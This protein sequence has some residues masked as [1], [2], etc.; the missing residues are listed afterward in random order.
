MNGDVYEIKSL[1]AKL[2]GNDLA[3]IQKAI[4]D[5]KETY[6]KNQQET[7]QILTRIDTRIEDLTN[8]LRK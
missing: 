2:G 5:L 7:L 6:N 8:T 4:D 3:H 1:I